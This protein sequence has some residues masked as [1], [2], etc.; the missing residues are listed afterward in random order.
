M[1][2]KRIALTLALAVSVLLV[3]G[4]ISAKGGGTYYWYDG[5]IKRTVYLKGDYVAEIVPS[6]TNSRMRAADPAA[7]NAGPASGSVRIWKVAAG[8]K[9]RSAKSGLKTSPVFSDR[10]GGSRLRALPGNVIVRL[11]DS[12]SVDQIEAWV[13][14]R[15]L[16][17]VQ[18]LPLKGNW[19]V[20]E[21]APGLAGLTLANQLHAR[22]DV[23]NAQPNWWTQVGTR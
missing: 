14:A 5:N 6:G 17:L 12:L 4:S 23:I 21:S 10:A 22:S 18:H 16:K 19:I 2:T 13:K 9:A 8:S 1:N 20:V 15:G 11:G 3:V 7:R